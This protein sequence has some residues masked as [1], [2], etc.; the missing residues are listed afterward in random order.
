MQP[1]ELLRKYADEVDR[2]K[3]DYG[4][5][6]AKLQR[7]SKLFEIMTGVNLSRSQVAMFMV[8]EKLARQ[9]YKHGKD[10]CG[11][12][13]CYLGAVCAAVEADAPDARYLVTYSGTEAGA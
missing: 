13:C 9:S 12:A 2:H 11:D 8:C 7:T 5:F 1:E 4:D 3:E 10:N 6:L